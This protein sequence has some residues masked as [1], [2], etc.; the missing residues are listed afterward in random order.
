[1][2]DQSKVSA[3]IYASFISQIEVFHTSFVSW[4]L[5]H[6]ILYT[7]LSYRIAL[8]GIKGF[9]CNPAA[10]VV[11]FI[12]V[13]PSSILC[14]NIDYQTSNFSRWDCCGYQ[15]GKNRWILPH[16]LFVLDYHWLSPYWIIIN[17]CLNLM[18][19][20]QYNVRPL[21]DLPSA[22]RSADACTCPS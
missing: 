5:T 19:G 14:F 21:V 16:L 8:N 17:W 12:S 3:H 15:I 11:W 10:L 13:F 22:L 9:R 2:Q 20:W 7:S 1:M 6:V 4:K 18:F